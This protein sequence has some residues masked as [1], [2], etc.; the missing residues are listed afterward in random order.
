[1]EVPSPMGGTVKSVA[2]KAGDRVVTAGANLL[3]DGETVSLYT[4]K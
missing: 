4:P 3:L 1:M 2:L